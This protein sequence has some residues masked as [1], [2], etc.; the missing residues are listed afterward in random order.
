VN[1]PMR[2]DRFDDSMVAF[3][4]MTAQ[5]LPVLLKPLWEWGGWPLTDEHFQVPLVLGQAAR[6]GV[7]GRGQLGQ[8]ARRLDA[9]LRR[10]HSIVGPQA[11]RRGFGG[12]ELR[13]E[14]GMSACPL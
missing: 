6:R 2:P 10:W 8:R 7:D 14:R 9:Q 5:G 12:I 1:L 4:R 13:C 3:E 11:H